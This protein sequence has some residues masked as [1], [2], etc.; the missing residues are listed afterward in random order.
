MKESVS[1]NNSLTCPF[2]FPY[3]N[4]RFFNFVYRTVPLMGPLP[5]GPHPHR[6]TA[7][8]RR[9]TPVSYEAYTQRVRITI[10]PYAFQHGLTE[11]QILTAF[12]TGSTTARIRQRDRKAD[13]PRWGVIGFDNEARAIQLVV[14]ALM[15]GDMLVIHARYLTSGFQQEMRQAL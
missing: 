5:E 6:T 2:W 9:T 11:G 15:S 8:Q 13:P 1:H 7:D 10:H 12:E 14:V 4:L 3:Q